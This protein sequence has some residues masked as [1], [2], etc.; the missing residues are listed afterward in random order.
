MPIRTLSDDSIHHCPVPTTV[1]RGPSLPAEIIR[2]IVHH[3]Q[4]NCQALHACLLVSHAWSKTAVEYLYKAEHMMSDYE[5]IS[6]STFSTFP[7]P[8]LSLAA[9][10]LKDDLDAAT[11]SLVS[12]ALI[13]SP[14]IATS[15]E[16]VVSSSGAGATSTMH[17]KA[18]RRSV[19]E[20]SS[21]VVSQLLLK[22][23]LDASLLHDNRCSYDY[24]SYLNK[25]SCPWFEALIQ[26]WGLFCGEWRGS[27]YRQWFLDQQDPLQ[28]LESEPSMVRKERCFNRMIRKA[29]A[30]CL[31]VDE[32]Q[33]SA[34]IQSETLIYAFQ[35]MKHLTWIDLK[36]CQDLNDHVFVAI[37]RTVRS[38][39][40]LRLH[41]SNMTNVSTRAVADVILAQEKDSLCQFKIIDGTNIFDDDLVLKAIGLRHGKSMKR[42]TLA[43][44]ELE[45]SGLQEYGPLC[46]QLASLNLEYSSGVTNDVVIPIL[47]ACHHLMKLD[48]TETD[49]TQMTIQALSTASDSTDP[50]PGRF[51]AMKRL[52]L[53][54][55]DAPFTTNLFLP[56]AE[57]CP[58]LEE[59]HMN[60]IL[61]DTF[62]DFGQFIVKMPKL[63]DLDIGNVF[64]EFLDAN[65]MG[66]VDA[67]PDLR[68][69]SIANTQITNVSLVY[70]AE[71]AHHLCDL[72]ILGCDQVTKS[73]LV[74]FLDKLSN[75]SGFRRLDI[76][77]CRLEECAVAEIRDRAKTMVLGAG[78]TDVVEIEGDD[79]FA[80]S[81]LEEEREDGN[82]E[83]ED[84][85]EDE[86]EV[87][88]G[89]DLSDSQ[90]M[91]D[92]D[93]FE[94]D[95]SDYSDTYS[96]MEEDSTL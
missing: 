71:R 1:H 52:I 82:F 44:C 83:S 70:L 58:N 21:E 66:L 37:A 20:L 53:N 89:D 41:G 75:K 16:I 72:C 63:K 9:L 85:D 48:L 86:N 35:R 54:N 74:E 61:A 3:L 91:Y 43:I 19:N 2:L 57:A 17:P 33:S 60:S 81:L 69:L 92:S 65:L 29:S 84:D 95:L 36:E 28:L 22:R 50:Q 7:A 40:Y 5:F 77:Y 96:D 51:A 62:Q 80:G 87:E 46:T 47:D 55:I 76:T 30:R 13:E 39:S 64:P 10:T 15:K 42:L 32:F 4:D 73:G 78:S 79:Q 31:S 93:D 8:V 14:V 59:L 49:C 34:M 90:D 56:L 94:E 67:L 24:M 25:I 27:S 6:F 68:W 88:D 18:A 12:N 26:N 38:L 11:E 45:N 23:V